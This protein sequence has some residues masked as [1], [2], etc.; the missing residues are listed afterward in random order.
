M[1]NQVKGQSIASPKRDVEE[2]CHNLSTIL[3]EVEAVLQ[4]EP[5]EMKQE[6]PS[7]TSTTEQARISKEEKYRGGGDTNADTIDT[8]NTPF[9]K[10]VPPPASSSRSD[11]P[12]HCRFRTMKSSKLTA[13]RLS[14]AQQS[15]TDWFSRF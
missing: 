9:P 10:G 2:A 14:T 8:P 11:D 12:V 15:N 1:S 5:D 4:E 13:P 7:N 6:S 3:Q